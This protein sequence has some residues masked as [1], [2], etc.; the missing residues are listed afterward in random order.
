MGKLIVDESMR[1][2]VGQLDKIAVFICNIEIMPD[3]T[4]KIT[5]ALDYTLKAYPQGS[6]KRS[7]WYL[8]TEKEDQNKPRVG[9]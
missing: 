7:H 1:G 8:Q 5:P 3:G 9:A 2:V 6:D 4:A